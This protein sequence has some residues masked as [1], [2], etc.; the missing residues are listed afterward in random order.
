ML[1]RLLI[2]RERQRAA[3][4]GKPPKRTYWPQRTRRN[5][6]RSSKF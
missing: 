1:S 2:G 4:D 6:K 5:T 3:F